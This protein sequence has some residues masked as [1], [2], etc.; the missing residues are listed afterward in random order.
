MSEEKLHVRR[1][2]IM[3][4]LRQNKHRVHDYFDYWCYISYNE[5]SGYETA[6]YLRREVFKKYHLGETSEWFKRIK[7]LCKNHF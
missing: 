4:V 3:G 2:R 1:G 5:M 6:Y 7:D